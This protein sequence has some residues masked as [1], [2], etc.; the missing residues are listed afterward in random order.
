M[1]YRLLQVTLLMHEKM[2][3]PEYCTKVCIIQQAI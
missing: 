2:H 1:R 3:V